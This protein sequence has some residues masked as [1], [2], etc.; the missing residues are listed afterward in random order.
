[1]CTTDGVRN[2]PRRLGTNWGPFSVQIAQALLVVP[3]S[4]PKSAIDVPFH[5]FGFQPTDNTQPSF[6][7]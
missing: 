6:K 3:K 5:T 7:N 1:M 4:I 2:A